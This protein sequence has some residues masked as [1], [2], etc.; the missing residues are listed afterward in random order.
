MY[1]GQIINPAYTGIWDK[2][3]FTALV[4]KQFAGL[5]K[6][7]VTECISFHSPVGKKM[8]G[9][10]VNILNDLFGFEHRL[11]IHA[12]YAHEIKL[13]HQT[14]IRMGV[15]FGFE[16]YKNPLTKYNLDPA[17][18]LDE[19]FHKDIDLKFLPDFG[20]G[21]FLYRNNF[22]VGVSVP[23]IV[24]ND[25]KEEI[26]NY[27]TDAD[28]RVFYLNGGYV[29]PLDPLNLIVFKPTVLMI[30]KRGSS[31]QV[32]MSANFL[33]CETL[34]LGLMFRSRRAICITG[35]WMVNDRCRVGFA[36][37]VT[38]NELYPYQNGTFELAF[39]FEMDFWGR[40]YLPPKYF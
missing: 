5:N 30:I 31:V 13:T 40:G 22:Y 1:N 25:L 29:F 19:A 17:N 36:V 11:S 38:H 9:I 15:N 33:F 14:R 26:Y 8:D 7:P 39:A 2:V 37:D 23:D 10:G 18:N 24:E 28:V 4:R 3:G 27:S 16:N 20:A 34:W 35:N 32:D 12:N 6:S 21:F